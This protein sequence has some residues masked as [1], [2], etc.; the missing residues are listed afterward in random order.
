MNNNIKLIKSN[1]VAVEGDVICFLEDSTNSK[2]YVYYT[3]NEIVGVEPSSTVKIYVA[4]IKQGDATD[5]PITDEEWGKLKGFMGD[6]LKDSTNANV[7]YLP[8]TE[9]VNPN[10]VDERVIAMPTM[11][12]YINK[13]RSAYSSNVVINENITSNEPTAPVIQ[14]E[15]ISV[16][17]DVFTPP[18]AQET[19]NNLAS[20]V[21]PEVASVTDQQVND[22]PVEP[23]INEPSIM[24]EDETVKEE[25]SS[26]KLERIDIKA[27]EGKYNS[28]IEDIKALES[29]EIEA[30]KRYNATLELNAMHN[31]QHASYV[32]GEQTSVETAPVVEPTPIVA[33]PLEA[34]PVSSDINI[35]TNWFDMPAQN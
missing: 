16:E 24:V 10:I 35:E 29:K 25:P 21:V 27:I 23:A 1:G 34:A 31:Q 15:S 6:V 19:P 30:A 14:E 5:V 9:L 18:V 3:L 26:T 33:E 12:D 20:E 32:Q 28:M 4:K 13:Q 7:K 2:K 17:P 22:V 8:L 11:Y